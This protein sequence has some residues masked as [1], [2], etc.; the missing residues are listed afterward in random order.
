MCTE[1]AHHNEVQRRRTAYGQVGLDGDDVV[2]Q[3][4]RCQR[5]TDG[6]K[7]CSVRI[8]EDKFVLS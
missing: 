4:A 2:D 8:S 3:Q 6:Q 5:R 1:D 7:I